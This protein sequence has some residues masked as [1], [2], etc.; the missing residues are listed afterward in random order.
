MTSRASDAAA[1]LSVAQGLFYLATGLWPLLSMGT[2]ERV[3][4]PKKE[5]WLVK[6]VGGLIA[7]IG[8]VLTS[9]GLRRRVSAETTAL[10]LGSAAFLT[11]IDLVYVAKRRIAPVYLLDAVAEVGLMAAWFAALKSKR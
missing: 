8:G 10:A 3:T 7:T 11:A 1:P 4:G 5:R 2:F 6:T 9:A